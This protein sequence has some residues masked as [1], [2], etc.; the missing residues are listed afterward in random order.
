M[1]NFVDLNDFFYFMLINLVNLKICVEKKFIDMIKIY[2][3]K[4]MNVVWIFLGLD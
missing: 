1:W 4:F 3:R 2:I